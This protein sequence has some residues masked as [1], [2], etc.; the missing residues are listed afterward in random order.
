ML[1]FTCKNRRL[2]IC[3]ILYSYS[4]IHITSYV[5]YHTDDA[6]HKWRYF[7]IQD[8]FLGHVMMFTKVFHDS[9]NFTSHILISAT[10]RQTYL[11]HNDGWRL[12]HN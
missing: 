7:L 3:F 11:S 4:P 5:Y 9:T 6:V 12:L 1:L 8:Y 10:H 2:N